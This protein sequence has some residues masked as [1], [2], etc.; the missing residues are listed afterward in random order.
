VLVH[1]FLCA[2]KFSATDPVFKATT[3]CGAFSFWRPA[4]SHEEWNGNHGS[5][6]WE[7]L[8]DVKKSNPIEVAEHSVARGIESKPAFAWWVNFTLKKRDQ[9]IS[10]V[11]KRVIKKTH[12]FG[13]R[14]PNDVGEAHV[15]DKAS[16]NTLWTDA[17]AKEM[18]NVRVVFDVK[19]GDEKAPTGFQEIRCHGIFDVKMDGFARKCRMVARGHTTEVPK[20][21]THTSVVS[22]ESVQ[23]VLTTVAALNNL[24]VKAANVQ[25]DI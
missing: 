22:R 19:E 8:A 23:I 11:K 20:T 15:L 25:N 10:A 6:S 16:G 17:I 18:K 12:K 5:T 13:M 1:R 3:G 21:L 4:H 9:I 2:S 7:R 24:K 14:V